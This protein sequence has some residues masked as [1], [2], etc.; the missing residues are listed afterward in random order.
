VLETETL[1]ANILFDVIVE[2]VVGH[3]PNLVIGLVRFATTVVVDL[4]DN[5]SDH[6]KI[7]ALV[8]VVVVENRE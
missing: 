8:V 5:V 2:I 6:R 1:V 4:D 7:V 3:S